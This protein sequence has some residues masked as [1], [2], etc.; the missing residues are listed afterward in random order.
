VNVQVPMLLT[1]PLN[2]ESGFLP[3][4]LYSAEIGLQFRIVIIA[5]VRKQF[6]SPLKEF[7]F[8]GTRKRI[9]WS[10]INEK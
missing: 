7:T 5:S 10:V 6:S 4:I 1:L 2:A 9:F 3:V 8:I